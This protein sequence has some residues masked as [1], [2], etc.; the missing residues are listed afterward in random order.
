MK[1]E[2]MQADRD[3][4]TFT[5]SGN[6]SMNRSADAS[7]QH[8]NEGIAGG[9]ELPLSP[10]F[11]TNAF[12]DKSTRASRLAEAPS[13]PRS[14]DKWGMAWDG[15]QGCW[16][17]R[18]DEFPTDSGSNVSGK[19]AGASPDA[20]VQQRC[21]ERVSWDESTAATGMA[22]APSEPNAHASA[23]TSRTA[24]ETASVVAASAILSITAG[25]NPDRT[26]VCANLRSKTARALL[27]SED[28][29][30]ACVSSTRGQNLQQLSREE[31]RERRA[32]V[33]AERRGQSLGNAQA[34]EEIESS[35]STHSVR[36][37]GSCPD[38]NAL[39]A[40]TAR[41]RQR[42][43]ER[44]A[45]DA[46]P[47]SVDSNARKV[48][49]GGPTPPRTPDCSGISNASWDNSRLQAPSELRTHKASTWARRAAG[50]AAVV[51]AAVAI[52]SR[53]AGRSGDSRVWVGA[54]LRGKTAR[55]LLRSEDEA[56]ACVSSTRGLTLHQ[57][58]RAEERERRGAIFAARRRRKNAA[59]RAA[60]AAEAERS[61]E[62]VEEAQRE[63]DSY[64]GV[65]CGRLRS[66]ADALYAV[67]KCPR[68][69][70]TETLL[71]EL[72]TVSTRRE[73]DELSWIFRARHRQNLALLL[74]RRA[75]PDILSAVPSG[76]GAVPL[77]PG[78]RPQYAWSA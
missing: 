22:Q 76:S 51:V 37:A 73:W 23:W 71:S 47:N 59:E 52:L 67:L 31:Q 17:V 39:L 62:A 43:R 55:A 46:A 18:R 14:Q 12:C 34:K 53:A 78:G 54:N 41:R 40:E 35:G 36:S 56:R 38:A 61:K 1:E 64:A 33:Y 11:S 16:T 19:S 50:E 42:L 28:E 66:V 4:K 57:L 21:P 68:P 15:Q 2:S 8:S 49:P 30:R 13:E 25:R 69:V 24:G 9:P 26:W 75:D 3:D 27:R 45:W 32:S 74:Q 77:Q 29:A 44:V 70:A 58:S 48:S 5:K 72:L 63:I 20:G 60:A 6:V 65:S 10:V 7:V